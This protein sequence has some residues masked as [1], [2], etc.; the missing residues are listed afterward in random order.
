MMLALTV[1]MSVTACG[2][3]KETGNNRTATEEASKTEVSK[4]N[5]TE[6]LQKLDDIKIQTKQL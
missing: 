3:Q 1:A 2:E 5:E 6:K 4:E